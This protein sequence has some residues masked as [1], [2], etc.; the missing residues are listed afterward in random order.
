MKPE[1]LDEVAHSGWAMS[2]QENC[3]QKLQKGS[4]ILTHSSSSAWSAHSTFFRGKLPV[5]EAMSLQLRES[6][7]CPAMGKQWVERVD[8]KQGVYPEWAEEEWTVTL[9]IDDATGVRISSRLSYV[10][11][12]CKL[13]E[14]ATWLLNNCPFSTMEII[15][16]IV[17]LSNWFYDCHDSD[18]TIAIV[19]V[20]WEQSQQLGYL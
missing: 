15:V 9:N 8:W 7:V 12:H 13:P 17:V 5:V 11:Y 16:F 2:W 6:I 19:K 1:A 20:N 4:C 10:S 14:I 3:P 18:F